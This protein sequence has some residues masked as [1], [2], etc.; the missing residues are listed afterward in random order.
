MVTLAVIAL[1][2]DPMHPRIMSR[3]HT[4]LVHRINPDQMRRD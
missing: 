4:V 2:L 1:T 3:R